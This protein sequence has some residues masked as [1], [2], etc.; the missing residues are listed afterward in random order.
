MGSEYCAMR[1][2]CVPKRTSAGTIATATPHRQRTSYSKPFTCT[3]LAWEQD[4][5]HRAPRHTT[6]SE[7][8]GR[9]YSTYLALRISIRTQPR[10]G[11][12]RAGLFFSPLLVSIAF[13]CKW[14]GLRP[15]SALIDIG[16][17]VLRRG[18]ALAGGHWSL[19]IALLFRPPRSNVNIQTTTAYS[20][21]SQ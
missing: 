13:P 2:F 6:H 14:P 17:C 16:P 5:C 12:L 4:Q 21:T 19:Q 9:V 3:H 7:R 18:T 20:R 15:G 10:P 11:G 8:I 1:L